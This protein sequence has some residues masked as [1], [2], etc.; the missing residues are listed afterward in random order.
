[1]LDGTL[2]HFGRNEGVRKMMTANRKPVFGLPD[3]ILAS[4]QYAAKVVDSQR[5][6]L[7]I[8]K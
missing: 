5:L 4:R 6:G 3:R 7:S 8:H 1:M 2:A